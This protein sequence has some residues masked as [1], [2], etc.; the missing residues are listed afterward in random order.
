MFPD[1]DGN[2]PVADGKDGPGP[3]LLYGDDGGS[4]YVGRRGIGG[5]T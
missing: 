1:T 4:E 2:P 3:E 5:A